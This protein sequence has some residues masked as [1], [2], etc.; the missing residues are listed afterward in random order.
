MGAQRVAI[1]YMRKGVK[2]MSNSDEEVRRDDPSAMGRPQAG[3]SLN[4]PAG[5][6]V[7]DMSGE[8]L[9]KVAAGIALD[10]Y[11]RLEKG[12]LFP[13]E[14]YIPKSAITRIEA[15]GVHLNVAKGDIK[16]RGW[17]HPPSGS[18]QALGHNEEPQI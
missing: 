16:N 10:D 18:V 1:S 11:F 4:V 13:Q 9:G 3:G 15:D 2:A 12:L 7:Y 5:A 17:D 6:T 8:K 14:Y